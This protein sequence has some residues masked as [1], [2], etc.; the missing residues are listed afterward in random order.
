VSVVTPVGTIG[1]RGT[2]FLVKLEDKN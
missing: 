2:R 1:I